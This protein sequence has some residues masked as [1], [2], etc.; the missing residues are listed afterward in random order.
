[1]PSGGLLQLKV[2]PKAPLKNPATYKI[3]GQ[4]VL[5]PDVPAKCTGQHTY[6]HDLVISGMLHGRV[7]R[8]PSPGAKLL[9]VDENSP[10]EFPQC[11]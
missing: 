4:P 2:D 8:P 1:M 11:A 9:S 3:V 5:R 6:V 7:I 10:K